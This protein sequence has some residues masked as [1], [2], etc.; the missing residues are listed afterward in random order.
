MCACHANLFQSSNHS[1][2]TVSGIKDPVPAKCRATQ[3]HGKLYT[4]ILFK[5]SAKEPEAVVMK[6][7]ERARQEPGDIQ[8][9]HRHL[10]S[11]G[12]AVKCW[13]VLN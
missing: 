11:G 3:V 2:D 5:S 10:P 1:V 12:M 4:F 7:A 8:R 13:P 9:L 6:L